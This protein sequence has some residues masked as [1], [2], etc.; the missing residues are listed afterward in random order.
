MNGDEDGDCGE[1]ECGTDD[2]YRLQKICRAQAHRLE[3][4][5]REG[6]NDDDGCRSDPPEMFLPGTGSP[7][8]EQDEPVGDGEL[9]EKSAL[10]AGGR[11]RLA[12]ICQGCCFCH[13]DDGTASGGA[14]SRMTS[15]SAGDPG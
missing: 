15:G 10:A 4:V 1:G 11:G 7:N 14:Y 9:D 6:G 5:E 2:P 8:D 12:D 3:A 13:E